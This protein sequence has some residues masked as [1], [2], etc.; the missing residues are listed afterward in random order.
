MTTP[1]VL[2]CGALAVVACTECG[3][4]FCRDCDENMHTE[5]EMRQHQRTSFAPP[6]CGNK[7]GLISTLACPECPQRSFC[8]TCDKKIHMLPRNKGHPR[9][10]LA[11]AQLS[12]ANPVPPAADPSAAN[13]KYKDTMAAAA[14][15]LP[16][17]D[18][19]PPLD[20]V[21]YDFKLACL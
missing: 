11:M 10:P 18:S 1:C 19:R 16:P 5:G 20:Y 14:S 12:V 7:C 17:E 13:S 21:E 4:A 15:D 6:P 2:D 8:D 3:D 9:T